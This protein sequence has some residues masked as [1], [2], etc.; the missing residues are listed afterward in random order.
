MDPAAATNRRISRV[1]E[2]GREESF[3]SSLANQKQRLLKQTQLNNQFEAQKVQVDLKAKEEEKTKKKSFLGVLRKISF[4]TRKTS[5]EEASS[6]PPASPPALL[7][8]PPVFSPP[9]APPTPPPSPAVTRTPVP[10]DSPL[11]QKAVPQDPI[12]KRIR[13]FNKSLKK[14]QS[15]RLTRAKSKSVE[16]ILEPEVEE[17]FSGREISFKV[18]K[19]MMGR[20]GWRIMPEDDSLNLKMNKDILNQVLESIKDMQ[21]CGQTVPD[22]ITVKLQ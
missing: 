20:I 2:V 16:K 22:K 1:I 6:P 15:F 9:P 7:L 13:S 17:T 10:Q 3:R 11:L 14:A 21:Y 18:K 19:T 12:L 8:P 4:R 5:K